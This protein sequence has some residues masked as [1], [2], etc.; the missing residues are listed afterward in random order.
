MPKIKIL[1]NFY[2]ATDRLAS[3]EI[4]LEQLNEDQR[5][6]VEQFQNALAE[7]ESP[8]KPLA[9]YAEVYLPP[10][11]PDWAPYPYE[12][13]IDK[14]NR[15]KSGLD[16]LMKYADSITG[17]A[18]H[19]YAHH[20]F[21]DSIVDESLR[22]TVRT[23]EHFAHL[24]AAYIHH[25]KDLEIALCRTFGNDQ[26]FLAYL[27]NAHAM[28]KPILSEINNDPL[29][30]MSPRQLADF[31]SA[32]PDK[33]IA[34]HQRLVTMTPQGNAW[35]EM[36]CILWKIAPIETY[37]DD[38]VEPIFIAPIY[39]KKL[40]IARE[41]KRDFLAALAPL[42]N[43]YPQMIK[44]RNNYCC[45]AEYRADEYA[46][47]HG[48]NAAGLK[49]FFGRVQKDELDSWW[50]QNPYLLKALKETSR[51][52][53]AANKDPLH[54]THTERTG[55]ME[56]LER[57]HKWLRIWKESSQRSAPGRSIK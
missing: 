14:D 51:K 48:K 38:K 34:F 43:A 25:P 21:D 19:E 2:D 30:R 40:R 16:F 33:A 55:R 13:R 37:S 27:A 31:F 50:N 23:C 36:E 12:M 52:E 18:L 44:Y 53:P 54:P 6:V 29:F 22:K 1:Q 45:A 35:D 5:R 4:P 11:Y 20:L 28:L 24:Y 9:E 32:Y 26:A 3:R 46:A 15:V 7:A 47:I 10:K 8:E 49:L 56:Q 57:Q 42:A 39:E 17:M 41:A